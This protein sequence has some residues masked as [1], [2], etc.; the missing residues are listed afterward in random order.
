MDKGNNNRAMPSA[1]LHAR[2]ADASHSSPQAVSTKGDIPIAVTAAAFVYRIADIFQE[3][4]VGPLSRDR[5]VAEAVGALEAWEDVAP[6]GT[7]EY[8]WTLEGAAE[9]AAEAMQY[10]EAAP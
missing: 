7:P 8:N 1:S 6:F 4:H 10:W 9:A 3:R 2:A 5:A